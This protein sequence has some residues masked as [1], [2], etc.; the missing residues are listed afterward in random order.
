MLDQYS[1]WSKVRYFRTAILPPTIMD[2]T[3]EPSTTDIRSTFDW[4]DVDGAS[5][6]VLQV[7]KSS[8]FKS[9]VVKVNVTSSTYTPGK[10]LPVGTLYWRVM[11]K[12][13]NGLVHGRRY[14]SFIS[15]YP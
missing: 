6:Y 14:E 15:M 9:S 2:L 11:A 5:S 3:N 8:S 10:D 12:G 7:S 4:S 13:P 1:D